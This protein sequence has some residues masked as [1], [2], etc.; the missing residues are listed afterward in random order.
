MSVAFSGV[1]KYESVSI[2]PKGNCYWE[3][4]DAS[5][6]TVCKL[7]VTNKV[8]PGLSPLLKCTVGFK[9]R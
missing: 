3:F 7:L 6:V 8:D 5:T 2:Q 1:Y 9:G 4:S